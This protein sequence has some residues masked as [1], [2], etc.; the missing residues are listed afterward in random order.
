[1]RYLAMD[2]L[3]LLKGHMRIFFHLLECLCIKMYSMQAV[4]G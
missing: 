2:Y 3:I 4:S 1:M